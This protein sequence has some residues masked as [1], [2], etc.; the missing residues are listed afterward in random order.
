[1]RYSLVNATALGFD[2]V[3]LPGGARTAE[4]LLAAC[5]ASPAELNRLAGVHPGPDRELRWEQ[6]RDRSRRLRPVL[7]AVDLAEPALAGQVQD[8]IRGGAELLTRI[9][10]AP[11]GDLEA[12]AEF[13]RHEALEATWTRVGGVALQDF[14]AQLAGD[15]LVDAATSAYCAD[16]LEDDERR[17]LVGPFLQVRRAG[18]LHHADAT[19]GVVGAL[20]ANVSAWGP[21]ER[22]SLSAAVDATRS[23]TSRWAGAMH[24]A[25]WAA[26]LSGR[27]RTAAVAQLHTVVAFSAAGF[28][29]T[30]AA[31][32]SWNALSGVVQALGV[33]DLLAGGDLDVLVQPWLLAQGCDPREGP[34]RPG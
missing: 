34:P 19:T 7:S 8:G 14:S 1:M 29:T 11:L 10:E 5:A 9:A 12:L 21:S 22:A 33:A 28:T 25:G 31:L 16:L 17:R 30:E 23:S 3:R 4:V 20:L 6:V 15:L 13:V 27:T 32:G 24:E 26:H 18:G 2:L